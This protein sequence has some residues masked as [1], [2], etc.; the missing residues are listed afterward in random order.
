MTDW[1]RQVLERYGQDVTVDTADGER[2][3]RAFLQPMTERDERARSDVTSIGWVDGRLWL[4]LGQTALEEGEALAW[5]ATRFRVRSCRPY[6]IGNALSHYWAALDAYPDQRARRYGCP[7][8]A[9]AVE[10]AESRTVGFCNYLG[11]VFDTGA[12]A[13]RELYG[14]QLEAVISI[15][16]RGQRAADCEQ[17]CETAAEV[18]LGRLPAGI[19]P[20]ELNWE[21]LTWERETG[22]FLRRGR[23]RCRAYFLARAEE[24]DTVFLDFR[25]KGAVTT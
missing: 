3:V 9:V 1:V 24:G 17:G 6:Y 19:R 2:T 22:L 16:I 15:E 23:L 14:K 5:E 10:T 20:G 21:A 25:L 12:G 18:L 13:P 7:V 4:Y 11:E 8:A